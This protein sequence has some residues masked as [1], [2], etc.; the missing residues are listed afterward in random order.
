[1]HLRSF[2]RNSRGILSGT[3]AQRM[4]CQPKKCKDV[5]LWSIWDVFCLKLYDILWDLSTTNCIPTWPCWHWQQMKCNPQQCEKK[6]N[7]PKKLLSGTF[8]KFCLT[9]YEQSSLGLQY[10]ELHIDATLCIFILWIDGGV[11]THGWK[12]QRPRNSLFG[13]LSHPQSVW[14]QRSTRAWH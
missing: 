5:I 4:D 3:L 7:N 2:S 6:G 8:K 14:P 12:W 10:N 13:S 11:V 1:M 9:L